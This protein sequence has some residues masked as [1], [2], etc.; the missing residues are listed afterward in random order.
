VTRAMN[1]GL[2]AR[3]SVMSGLPDRPE[4]YHTVTIELSVA[5][6]DAAVLTLTQDNNK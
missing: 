2:V 4:N 1:K 3:Q 5:G 6:Q